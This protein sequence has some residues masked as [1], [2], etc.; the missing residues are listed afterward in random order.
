MP[1]ALPWH[2]EKTTFSE[3]LQQLKGVASKRVIS[4]IPPPQKKVNKE[5]NKKFKKKK[6][7]DVEGLEWGEMMWKALS[8]AK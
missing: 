6:Q 2:T 3:I 5:T 4:K 7:D 1:V 8:G